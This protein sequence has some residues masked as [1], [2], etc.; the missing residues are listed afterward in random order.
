MSTKIKYFSAAFLL[1]FSL[2]MS[3]SSSAQVSADDQGHAPKLSTILYGAAYYNEYVPAPIKEGRLEKDI[4]LMRQA[5]MNVVRM[6]ES[7]WGMWEPEDGKFDYAWMDKTID[8]LGEAGIKT[9]MGT[10]TYSIPTW[11]YA[12]YPD[13]LARPMKGEPTGYGMR[14]NMNIDDPNFRQ[15]AER[16]IVKLAQHY[17]DNPNVIGWQVDNET[18]G[19]G[20]TNASVQKEFVTW[21]RTKYTS[22]D[23]LNDA[24]LLNYWGEQVRS[25][26]EFPARDFTISPS[27][28]L[29]WTRFQQWRATQYVAWQADLVRENARPDQFVTQNSAGMT[30]P[31]VDSYQMFK[32]LDVV[33]NDIYFD[34]QDRDDGRVQTLQGNLARS[35]KQRNFF[36]AET[37]GQTTGWDASNQFPPYDGQMYQ[38]VFADIAN[39]ANMVSYWHWASLN[40]GQEIYWKGVLGHDLEPNRSYAEV[41]RVG[42]DLKRVGPELVDLKKENKVAVL[43]SVDS[44]NGISF[45]PYDKGTAWLPPGFNHDG[46]LRVFEKLNAALYKLN[47]EADIVYANQPDFSKY[48][49]LIV[50]VLYI[51]D[52][53]LLQKISDYVK[54][55][56]HVLMTYKSG[57]ANENYLVRWVTAPGPLREAAGFKYQETSTLADPLKLKGDPYGVGEGNQV[58]TI[59]EFILPETAQALAY[60]DHP[61]FGRYPAITRNTY[62][63][64]SLLYEGTELSDALQVAVLKDELKKLRLYGPD[65]D[66][67]EHA[68]IKHAIS[69]SGK[70]LHFYFNYSS[71]PLTL[72]Y[73][74]KA[75]IELLS[76]KAI[77]AYSPI[78]LGP[79]GVIIAQE[80]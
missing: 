60:Y 80:N 65:Q 32:V 42:N 55:G 61:F 59:A 36:V 37:I 72:N 28:K 17:K 19:Y 31:D 16:I 12:K 6:G 24:W 38:D 18:S 54:N 4:E 7:S 10:P 8:A 47:V 79:W 30:R 27:Y 49:L 48:S 34:W 22:V 67:P 15:Y 58:S 21:L 51:A 44:L 35:T 14:Q 75:A 76:G 9:I 52:D 25:W 63:K 71:D 20:A 70:K 62:G 53:A 1:T 77:A 3:A 33:G 5:G 23:E 43:Y 66:L 29:D 46:Y 13:I 2:F 11:M 78:K 73:T 56:G 41:S 39:G 45:M 68:V 26:D 74:Y 69:N 40:G 50:P 57:E 64:G